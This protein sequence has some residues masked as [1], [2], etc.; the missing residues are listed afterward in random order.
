MPGDEGIKK[1]GPT[2]SELLIGPMYDHEN[3]HDPAGEDRVLS[4]NPNVPYNPDDFED[5]AEKGKPIEEEV[6]GSWYADESDG[7]EWHGYPTSTSDRFNAYAFTAA[8]NGELEAKG[9]KKGGY[10]RVI[11]EREVE[12][13]MVRSE[14]VV[15]LT[16]TK[17]AKGI[18]LSKAAAA[19]IGLGHGKVKI[20]PVRPKVCDEYK[21]DAKNPM[22]GCYPK[23][24]YVMAERSHIFFYRHGKSFKDKFYHRDMFPVFN[25]A[26]LKT[27]EW[28]RDNFYEVDENGVQDTKGEEWKGL[29]RP[30]VLV[31]YLE[32]SCSGK[33]KGRHCSMQYVSAIGPFPS[34]EKARDF[35][36]RFS[37][38]YFDEIYEDSTG[39]TFGLKVYTGNWLKKAWAIRHRWVK[40]EKRVFLEEKEV[41]SSEKGEGAKARVEESA[42][43]VFRRAVQGI[44]LLFESGLTIK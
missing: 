23:E 2:G 41:A 32:N 15:L 27:E 11:Y 28:M 9:F 44:G 16:D 12:K 19:H 7:T 22:R 26:Q 4:V 14:V 10:V 5:I 29:V 42:D 33:G 38:Y 34:E 30:R 43:D 25:Y 3:L 24:I 39:I 35:A 1:T 17:G 37:S 40:N 18:D 31:E 20:R 6:I 13:K 36:Q 21:Y 8:I